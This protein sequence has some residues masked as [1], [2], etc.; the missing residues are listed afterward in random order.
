MNNGQRKRLVKGLNARKREESK[1]PLTLAPI[2]KR[3]RVI[4]KR[5]PEQWYRISEAP[6]YV[7]STYKRAG[8]IVRDGRYMEVEELK[9]DEG[10]YGARVFIYVDGKRQG[11]NIQSAL[12]SAQYLDGPT[13]TEV[14]ESI[15]DAAP[16]SKAPPAPAI[17]A[18]TEEQQRWLREN[19]PKRGHEA[20]GFPDRLYFYLRGLPDVPMTDEQL[21]HAIGGRYECGHDTIARKCPKPI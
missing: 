4:S 20:N 13:E 1:E 17:P 10:L 7:L 19:E 14:L 5:E 16:V 6:G 8:R 3:V 18:L 15:R 9:V 2:S 12:R 11:F 21:R